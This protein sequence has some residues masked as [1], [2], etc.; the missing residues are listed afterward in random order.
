MR[1]DTMAEHPPRIPGRPPADW[2]DD[3]RR[4]LA[5]T[6]TTGR[7]RPV[8]L[9]AV[10]AHHPTML[11]PYI[12]WA[13]AVALDAVLPPRLVALVTLRSALACDSDFEWGVHADRAR[14]TDV[15]TAEEIGRI[16]QVDLD[17][18]WDELERAV[19][20]AV[21]QLAATHTI[22]A[23]TWETLV[24]RLDDGQLV[25]LV[26][27]VGHYTMLAMIANASGVVGE[28]DWPP[29]GQPPAF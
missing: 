8:H 22:E 21:D 20:D 17:D 2:S 9:P 10:I 26:V 3:T 1:F 27:T 16:G 4:I 11:G 19:L 12:E 5:G 23:G 14:A 7:S 29:L 28:P 13:K 6:V 25:E 15:L 24:P 18:G